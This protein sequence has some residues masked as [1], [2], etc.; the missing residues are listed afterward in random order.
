V[1]GAHDTFGWFVVLPD[2][3]RAQSVVEVVRERAT[4]AVDS[5]GGRPWLLGCWTD[6]DVT[7]A[8]AGRTAL[9]LIGQHAVTKDELTAAAQRIRT[10][11][12]VD[13]LAASLVG[14]CHLVASVDGQVRVQGTVTGVRRVFHA[15]VNGVPVAADRADTL[16]DLAG[17]SFDE[18]RVALHLLHPHILYPLA[19]MPV[20]RGVDVLPG[21][22]YLVLDGDRVRCVRWWAP[23]E[24]MLPMREGARALRDALSDAVEARVAGLK[25]VSCDLGGLDSTAICSLTA[26]GDRTVAAFTA[27]SPDPLADDV[28]WAEKTIAALQGVEHHVI[29]AE[30][31]PLVFCALSIDDH[32]FDEPCSATVD[33][34]RWLEIGRRAADRG[35]RLHLTGFGGDEVLYGSIAHMHDLMTRRPRTALGHLRGFA[36]KYRW[37]WRAVLRQLADHRPYEQWLRAVAGSL[38]APRPSL[39]D[40]LLEWGFR[41]RMPPWASADAVGAVR[42]QIEAAAGTR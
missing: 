42:A 7:T 38:T 28:T 24:P 26:G 22:S 40:P 41:P 37:P 4:R 6:G 15:T 27:A 3:R 33:G 18:D 14:S 12:D 13:Q 17:A 8:C 31:M 36:A 30:E 34:E 35:S 25:L 11:L 39:S 5:P 19:G 29:A 16:A 10:V 1:S 32:G 23:P 9:A 21:D 20:W 2:S